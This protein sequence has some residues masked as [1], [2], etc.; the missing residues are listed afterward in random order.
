MRKIVRM[1]RSAVVYL[2]VHQDLQFI[3][4]NTSVFSLAMCISSRGDKHCGLRRCGSV[5]Q[6]NTITQRKKLTVY[7]AVF[8]VGHSVTL[9]RP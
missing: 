9:T 6:T 5:T 8:T 4:T 3:K 1:V 2:C 7:P